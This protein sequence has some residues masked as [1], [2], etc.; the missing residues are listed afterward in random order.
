MVP[1]T[2]LV[3]SDSEH[4]LDDAADETSHYFVVDPDIMQSNDRPQAEL[5]SSRPALPFLVQR[6]CD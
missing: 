2:L 1:P 3:L 4:F 5:Q 6:V